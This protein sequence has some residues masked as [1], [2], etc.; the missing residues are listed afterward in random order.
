MKRNYDI[1]EIN[2][3]QSEI[4]KMDPV[5][6]AET[7]DEMDA[8]DIALRF[9][10]L[11]KD[12]AA[13]TFAEM[14]GEKKREIIERFS[15]EDVEEIITELDEDELVDTLQELPA[16]M[17]RHLMDQF[18]VGERRKVINKLLG[19][20]QDSVGSIMTV[21]FLSAKVSVSGERVLERVKASTLD[22]DKLEQIWIT[23]NSLVLLGYVYLA[24]VL[25]E[26]DRSLEE[27]IEPL[28]GSVEA[29]EDQE[30]VAKLAYR[31]DLSEIPVTDS[32]GRLIG[33]V[34][35][36]DAIDVMHEEYQEDLSNIHGVQESSDETYLDRS[37]FAIA[38]DRTTW[39]IICLVTATLTGFI[40]QRYESLLATSVALAA[41][42]PMLM[43]SGGNAGTQASTTVIRF[44]YT[45]EVGFSDILKVMWKEMRVGFMTGL[46]LVI[47]NFV[48]MMLLGSHSLRIN[49]TVSLTLLITVMLSKMVGGMLPLIADKIHVDPTVMAGPIIT[50][51]VD[52]F[53]LL[54]YFEVASQLL[55]AM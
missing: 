36:E 19:Y 35:L 15:D 52:T 23:D 1:D 25:R 17:V 24:D 3:L 55:T 34:P 22:A 43:D 42:I 10:L 6:I 31:Y 12:L 7:F 9:K 49:L 41:Y 13:D 20:P 48:R 18:V 44:L 33:T 46:I 11:D 37:T 21:E 16:N 28:P 53:A 30:I 50:T 27:L 14:D 39:L 5:D 32:E 4:N 40:I 38:K 45:G 2:S 8:V 29:T 51:L 54:V 47:V 26:P